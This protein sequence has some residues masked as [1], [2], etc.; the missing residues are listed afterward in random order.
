M[1]TEFKLNYTEAIT[2]F[3]KILKKFNLKKKIYKLLFNSRGLEFEQFRDFNE[4]EDANTIDWSASARA[5]KLLS[6]QYIEER[7]VN[8]FF[9]V[10]TS[11]NM[12]FGS[13]NELKAEYASDIVLSLANVIISSSDKVGLITFNE[14]IINYLPPSNF[15]NQT[16]IMKDYLTNIKNYGNIA[17]FN[18]F[19]EFLFN[20]VKKRNTMIIIISDFLYLPTELEKNL[21]LLSAKG[22]VMAIAVR[23][24]LDVELPDTKDLL[25]LSSSKDN[26]SMVI[27]PSISQMAYKK[28]ATEQ[29]EKVRE[30]FKKTAV[31]FL[32]LRTDKLFVI[33]IVNF[34]Q[35]RSKGEEH[36]T[37]I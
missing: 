31:D 35:E 34:L 23:D 15:R 20:T 19:F 17:N 25:V 18:V 32:E 26:S 33:P 29:I 11:K 21:Q 22:E 12:L 1:S 14:K 27:D 28:I 3:E 37:I 13:R 9:V 36:G 24:P 6:R 7:E 4:S 8:F 16:F 30:V 2:E 10:D 5:N